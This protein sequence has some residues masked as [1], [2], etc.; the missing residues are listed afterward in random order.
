LIVEEGTRLAARIRR[1]ELPHPDDDDLADKYLI[2]EERLSTAGYSAYEVSNW[3]TG[4][5]T[6]CRHNLG[7]WRSHHWWGIGPGA[8]SH[9]AGVRW[10]NVKHPA[11][12]A[13]RLAGGLSPAQAREVLS[14]EQRRTERIM[15]ELRLADGLQ[16]SLLTTTERHRVADLLARR[17]VVVEE[18]MLILTAQGRLLADG[19]I[20]D[21]LD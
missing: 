6:R 8:H 10:W 17:L 20:R 13:S 21:L 9:I 11:A 15:L 12:Y 4:M 16:M 1:G 2:T 19:V 14:A 3:S 7:Y 5:A 18:G